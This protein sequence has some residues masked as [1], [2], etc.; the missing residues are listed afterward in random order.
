MT[1]CFFTGHRYFSYKKD[2]DVLD[3]LGNLLPILVENGV[4]DFYSGGA[5]G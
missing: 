4:T 3:Y 5:L 2:P 1:S